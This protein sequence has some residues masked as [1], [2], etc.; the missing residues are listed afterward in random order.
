MVIKMS[1]A[2][3]NS[4]ILRLNDF[5]ALKYPNDYECIDIEG[6]EITLN[7]LSAEDIAIIGIAKNKILDAYYK[8][9]PTGNVIPGHYKELFR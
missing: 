4:F 5:T 3:F 8:D 9:T 1:K 2:E 6:T 7:D